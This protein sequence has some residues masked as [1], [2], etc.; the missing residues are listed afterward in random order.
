MAL[1]KDSREFIQRKN[2]EDEIVRLKNWVAIAKERKK[3]K[4]LNEYEL[5]NIFGKGYTAIDLNLAVQAALKRMLK[6]N[7]PKGEE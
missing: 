3:E 1:K 7:R 6:A 5:K 4:N 2:L